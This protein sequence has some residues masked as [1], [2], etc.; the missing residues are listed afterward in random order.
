MKVVVDAEKLIDF[1]KKEN[2]LT[3]T[4]HVDSLTFELIEEAGIVEPELKY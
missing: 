3:V 1:L 4:L 2:W